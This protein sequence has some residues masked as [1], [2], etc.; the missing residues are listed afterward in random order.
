MNTT[1]LISA[2]AFATIGM[3]AASAALAQEATSDAWM[4]SGSTLTRAAVQADLAKARAD[5]G[6]RF[7]QLGFIEATA[8]TQSREAV[9]QATL[10]ARQNGELKSINAEVYG[11]VQP[12]SVSLARAAR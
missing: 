11:F 8:S 10:A 5:G 2:L 1:K 6:L 12:A 7:A 4:A 3:G 9:R